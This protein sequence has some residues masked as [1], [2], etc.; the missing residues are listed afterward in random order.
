MKIFIICP[1]RGATESEQEFLCE[2]IARLES[3]GN[4]VHYPLRDT[5]QVDPLGGYQIC[6]DN[7]SAIVSSDEVHIYWNKSSNGSLFD[8]GISFNEHKTRGMPIRIINRGDVE[9]I[10]ESQEI[11]KSFEQVLLRLDDLAVK[12]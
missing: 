4:N 8:L 7:Y 1:V 6:S 11:G 5:E 3:D 9:K 10:V 12:N 2:Y